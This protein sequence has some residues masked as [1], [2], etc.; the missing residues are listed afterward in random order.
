[1]NQTS[2]LLVALRG[3]PGIG[4][5]ALARALGREL[6]WP[7][8]DKD[9]IKEVVYGRTPVADELSYDLLFRL[10]QRQL[11]QGLNVVVDSPLMVSGLYA[12]ASR[13]ALEADARLVVLDCVLSD[14]EEHRRRIDARAATRPERD[15]AVQ[16]WA[17]FVAYRDRVQPRSDYVLDVPH[18][19]IDLGQSEAVTA[20]E[21]IMWLRALIQPSDC[22]VARERWD[23]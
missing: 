2:P 8:L 19:V 5:T 1:M 20:R 4:K 21:A 9:D 17:G 10:A 7:L 6:G 22:Q 11:Q 23:G 18:R 14:T 15:W 13:T 3:M 12:L 16:D